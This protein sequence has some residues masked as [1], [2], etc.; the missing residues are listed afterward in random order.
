MEARLQDS[1]RLAQGFV[2]TVAGSRLEG[3]IYV[4]NDAFRVGEYYAVRG[5]FHNPGE[6]FGSLEGP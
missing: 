1:R 3:W 6:Q 5:L 2:L 4:L